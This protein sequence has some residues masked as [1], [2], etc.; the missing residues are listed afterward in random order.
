[1]ILFKLLI[2]L[3]LFIVRMKMRQNP[4]EVLIHNLFVGFLMC[5]IAVA[6]ASLPVFLPWFMH[7]CASSYYA[8]ILPVCVPSN[9]TLVHS[10][11]WWSP[12]RLFYAVLQMEAASDYSY[13]TLNFAI[14]LLLFCQYRASKQFLKFNAYNMTEWIRE[15]NALIVFSAQLNDTLYTWIPQILFTT[16][17]LSILS[18]FIAIRLKTGVL[19]AIISLISSLF[20]TLNVICMAY[21]PAHTANSTAKALRRKYE[22]VVGSKNKSLA[23]AL[24]ACQ[25]A[26]IKAGTY[27]MLR[28]QSLVTLIYKNL[29]YTVVLL[30]L[31]SVMH[32]H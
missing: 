23:K 10:T 29:D 27:G 22:K 28:Q 1:M 25:P 32:K 7:T 19:I 26:S 12:M 13:L 18:K 6:G 2:S 31:A 17:F 30:S 20:T 8:E 21:F 24:H 16:S 5:N 3:P 14:L 4:T 15:Y 9:G 11:T